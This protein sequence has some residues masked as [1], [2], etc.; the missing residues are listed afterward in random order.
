M[1]E[2]E[3]LT[4]TVYTIQS[5]TGDK[6]VKTGKTR[7]IYTISSAKRAGGQYRRTGRLAVKNWLADITLKMCPFS[8][9][10]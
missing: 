2:G 6:V 1:C 9:G 10:Q 5:S 4:G 3:I 7:D 8:R